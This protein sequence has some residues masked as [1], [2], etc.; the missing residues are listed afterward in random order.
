[1]ITE[2][3]DNNF[4]KIKD[5]KIYIYFKTAMRCNNYEN[6]QN[7]GIAKIRRKRVNIFIIALYCIYM[8]V[9]IIKLHIVQLF[10]TLM[11]FQMIYFLIADFIL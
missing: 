8:H 1:M 3:Q 4:I 9:T 7:P 2:I 5:L 10:L 6:G 11:F